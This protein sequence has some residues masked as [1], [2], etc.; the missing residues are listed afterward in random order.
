M[1]EAIQLDLAKFLVRLIEQTS[2]RDAWPT[3][4]AIKRIAKVNIEMASPPSRTVSV[5]AKRAQPN[6]ISDRRS[7]PGKDLA[8]LARSA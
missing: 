3:L 8:A 2:E 7:K 4:M 1:P 5:I 6:P